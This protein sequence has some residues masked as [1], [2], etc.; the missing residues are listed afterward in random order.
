MKKVI[1][2]GGGI[3][4]LS[5]AYRL[6]KSIESGEQ[7]DYLL[8]EKNNR[9]GG[10]IL[11]EKIDGFTVEGGPDCF[12]SEKPSVAQIAQEIGIADRIIGSNEASKRTY[13][14]ADRKLHQLPD[15]LM[16]LVPTKIV[17][18][19]LSPLISWPGKIRMAFDLIIP[20]KQT[21]EDETLGSFVTRRLGREALDKI[22][23]PL[24]GGIHAGDPDQMSLKAS[25]PRFIQM[26]QKHG[27]LLKAM[28]AGRKNAPKPK[29]PEPGKAPKT[30]FMTFV[31]GMGELTQ[32]LAARLDQSKIM[33]GKNVT[34][35][36]K[37]D[38]KY[39]VSIEGT[40]TLEADAV[41][42]TAPANVTAE[43]VRDLD[44]E[45]SENLAAIPQATSATV[46]LAFKRSDIKESVES[47]G[48]IVPISEKRKIKAGTYSS[49]KWNYRTPSD[50]YVLLRAF[51]GGATNQELVF[52]D[53]ESLLKMVLD[54]LKDIIGLQAKPVMS[55]IYR[56][57]QGMPQYTVGHLERVDKIDA[58]L[59]L[60]PGLYIVG[61]SY[62]GVGVPDCINVGTQGAEK[63]L[64][65]P[66]ASVDQAGKKNKESA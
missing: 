55:K 32:K 57:V 45:M 44:R 34:G 6:Q 50:D 66:G 13:V 4:G 56:W 18:F 3:T 65:Y 30:F 9:L 60:N 7:V 11:S 23:E 22:A 51:V 52:Q 24:I 42:V 54:E 46:N 41:I 15:G 61:A 36:K 2:I 53:D 47:F 20:K 17:P 48:F 8:V 40:D 29:P 39:L 12:L 16:G 35:I 1:I 10:K 59:A 43:L 62:K 37:A 26:E 63:A 58:R 5:A 21:D 28:L 25:F 31:D 64:A 27:S 14:Y 33:M 49:T 19:A 38:G